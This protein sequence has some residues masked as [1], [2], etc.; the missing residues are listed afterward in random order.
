MIK[1][2]NYQEEAVDICLDFLKRKNPKPTIIVHPTGAGKSIVIGNLVSKIKEPVL[3]LQPSKEL[4]EQNFAKLKLYGGEASIYSASMDS[5]EIGHVTYATLGS[6]KKLG[7]KFKE[8]GVKTVLVD[9][10][11]EGYA[12]EDGSMFKNFI[13]DLDPLHI[14]G[15]TATPIRLKQYGDMTSKWS[16]LNMINRTIPKI[17]SSISQVVQIGYLVENKYWADLSYEEWDFD[18]SILKLNSTGAE[19]TEQSIKKS[20]ADQNINNNIYIRLKKLLNEGKSA[21]VFIDSVNNAEKMADKLGELAFCISSKTKKKDRD[22]AI[23]DFKSG[24]LKII[25]NYGTLA[26]GFDYPE[27]NTVIIGRPTNSLAV[28]YQQAGRVVRNPEFPNQKKALIIDFCNNVKRFGRLETLNFRNV[29]RYGWGMFTETNLLT[30]IPMGTKVTLEE[31]ERKSKRQKEDLIDYTLTFGKFKDKKL[32]ET[33]LGYRNWLL[34]NVDDM[35][36]KDISTQQFKDQLL[37]L[38]DTAPKVPNDIDKL[39]IVDFNNITYKLY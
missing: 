2:R 18:E 4:L 20:I 12:P 27:L 19:F 21:L 3:I 22:K 1:L 32:S 39:I 7:K 28:F 8:F 9:E 34:A 33:P 37:L 14:I 6:I 16:Q 23:N 35:P 30:G 36:I 17:F 13:K 5:K 10:V 15:F 24:K 25:T 31:L 11:H 38:L 29:E 26:K